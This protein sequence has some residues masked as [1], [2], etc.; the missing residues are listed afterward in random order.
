MEPGDRDQLSPEDKRR[1]VV[2]YL[3]GRKVPEIVWDLRKVKHGGTRR[4]RKLA[5]AVDQILRTQLQT[6]VRGG[7]AEDVDT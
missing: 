2:L 4:Y 3:A 7:E 5:D 1:I 6:R